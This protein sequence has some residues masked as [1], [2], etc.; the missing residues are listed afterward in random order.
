MAAVRLL[1]RVIA[2]VGLAIDAGVHAKLAPQYDAVTVHV[3]QGTLFR[4][5]A[6]VAALAVLL[7]LLWRRP[8]GDLFALLTAAGGLAALLVYRYVDVGTLGPF[9]NM[10][11]PV[12]FT[13]K[14]WAVVGQV[15]ALVAL[16]P[17]LAIPVRR[18]RPRVE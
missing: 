13:D 11:E 10:Y 12:W 15:L 4:I 5:E 16:V 6:G 1:L 3:S 14:V 7:V 17:L 8:L 2:A 9:P 18:P